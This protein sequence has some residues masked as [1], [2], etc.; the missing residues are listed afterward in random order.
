[1]SPV[2]LSGRCAWQYNPLRTLRTAIDGVWNVM[3]LARKC[4]ARVLQ[5]STSE[6]PTLTAARQCTSSYSSPCK[7][8]GLLAVWLSLHHRCRCMVSR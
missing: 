8:S 4:N 2:A 7:T 1:M 6:A 5:A 3:E